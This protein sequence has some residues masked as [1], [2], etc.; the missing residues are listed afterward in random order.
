[1]APDGKRVMSAAAVALQILDVETDKSLKRIEAPEERH[2]GVGGACC[3]AFS[4]DG[5][6]IVSGGERISRRTGDGD[7]VVR[8]WDAE[9]GKEVYKYEGHP[10]AVWSVA[11][12]PDGK[13]IAS[14]SDD[15][16]HIWHAPR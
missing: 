2:L 7:G 5:K 12:F 1:V 16:V 4:P 11:F 6:R 3:A 10:R 9:S 14:A 13:R 15:G 8:V